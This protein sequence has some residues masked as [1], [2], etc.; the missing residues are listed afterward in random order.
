[1]NEKP[2]TTPAS[3]AKAS[4][5]EI[6]A[7]WKKDGNTQKFLSGKLDLKTLPQENWD[8]LLKTK[9]L[10]LVIFT[11]KFKQNDSHPDLR[12]YLSRPPKGQAPAATEAQAAPAEP[13]PADDEII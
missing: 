2:Q 5:I 1:M 13:V 9:T 10:P 8:A 11:N 12:I 7:L 4:Q 3:Q 6:G